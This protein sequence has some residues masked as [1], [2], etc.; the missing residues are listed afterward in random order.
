MNIAPY[1]IGDEIQILDLFRISF[2]RELS[3]EY[4]K[5]RFV[6]NP[7]FDQLMISLMW[8]GDV[9]AGHYA[10]SATELNV[11]GKTVLSSLSGTTMTHPQYEKRG[12]FTK[13]ASE[14]Y[15]RIQKD[16][17]VQS[18]LGFPN[19]SSHYGLVK[20]LF[21]EDVCIV[22]TLTVNSA[23]IKPVSVNYQINRILSFEDYHEQFITKCI[24]NLGFGIFTNR[25][26]KYLNWRFLN[27][28]TNNY[29]CFE[30]KTGASLS[31]IIIYKLYS[32]DN[33]DAFDIDIVDI[34]CENDVE[35]MHTLIYTAI[36]NMGIAKI[37]TRNINMWIS[38][39]D[40]R[41]LELERLGFRI[42]K[43]LTYMCTKHLTT[44]LDRI[45]ISKGWYISMS[46][47]DVY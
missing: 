30:I 4:W 16:Y 5:W 40:K 15:Q 1:K 3:E 47:S 20:K 21:W 42:E 19:Q 10:V 28:P 27:C 31:G 24:R 34:F 7:L 33:G 37:K 41:H 9:L 6:E 35:T 14:L 36:E 11:Y 23:A 26:A 39:F 46:D 13:L 43:P 8:E 32:L 2:G 29:F 25:S 44:D 38:L 17:R 22:P 18:V 12:I 45:D